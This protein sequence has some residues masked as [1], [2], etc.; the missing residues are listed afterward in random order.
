MKDQAKAAVQSVLTDME[1]R[2]A[3]DNTQIA[4]KL[5][6][7]ETWET[8]SKASGS[9]K[10]DLR[11]GLRGYLAELKQTYAVE[12]NGVPPLVQAVDLD[13][14]WEAFEVMMES[15]AGN[16]FIFYPWL[17]LRTYNYP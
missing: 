8:F 7:T 12:I 11:I 9:N 10:G 15:S 6:Q 5:F 17:S 1:K 13:L 16:A 3:L 4:F 14:E 2:F